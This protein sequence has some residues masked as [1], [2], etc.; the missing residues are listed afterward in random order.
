ML[1]VVAVAASVFAAV[2][3][4]LYTAARADDPRSAAGVV[5][6]PVEIVPA[7]RSTV[8]PMEP[9]LLPLGLDAP[10]DPAWAVSPTEFGPAES[11]AA[12][13]S[14]EMI[15]DQ[16]TG[17]RFDLYLAPERAAPTTEA[18]LAPTSRRRAS[19]AAAP[20][21]PAIRLDSDPGR[22]VILTARGMMA[23]G[24][25]VRGSC[26]RYLSE[27]FARAGHDS[28]RTRSIVHASER[29]GPY[30][31]LDRIRPGDWLYIV[32]HPE[33]TPMGTHSV[34]FLGWDDRAHGYARVLQH[35]GGGSE[36]AGEERTYDVSRT[37][38]IVR[39]VLPR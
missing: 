17:L 28:W 21:P 32:N 30:A 23:R 3:G 2:V 4:G 7:P 37:Y 1:R 39:P 5:V 14:S 27:V 33:T 25:T 6:E 19:R 38:R 18:A 11:S 36:S 34:L 9:E 10:E 16:E 31:D 13:G 35:S 22:H 26:Y 12:F 29:E 24:D 20:A 8:A 15:L